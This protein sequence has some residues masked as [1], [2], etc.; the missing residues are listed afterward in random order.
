MTLVGHAGGSVGGT[1]CHVVGAAQLCNHGMQWRTRHGDALL[2]AARGSPW[3]RA[4]PCQMACDMLAHVRQDQQCKHAHGAPGRAGRTRPRKRNT[5]RRTQCCA[6][7]AHP[8]YTPVAELA[9]RL[10]PCHHVPLLCLS[11]ATRRL[12]CAGQARIS[13][14]CWVGRDT[15]LPRAAHQVLVATKQALEPKHGTLHLSL[16]GDYSHS[17]DQSLV[18]PGRAGRARMCRRC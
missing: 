3:C 5:A 13:W 4:G 17:C 6:R 18:A 7:R 15:V 2:H 8:M 1:G 14:R 12:G 9:H 10:Q 11:T 16:F